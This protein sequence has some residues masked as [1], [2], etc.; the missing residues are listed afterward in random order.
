MLLI[1]TPSQL[2]KAALYFLFVIPLFLV[3]TM[4]I[5]SLPY[6]KI[7]WALFE[8]AAPFVLGICSISVFGLFRGK[9]WVKYFIQ[10]VLY[11]WC[12]FTFIFALYQES[13]IQALFGLVLS[14][15][16]L[17][18]F[19]YLKQVFN[20]PYLSPGMHWYQGFPETLPGLR[21]DMGRVA[22][23]SEE[24]VFVLGQFESLT[25]KNLP[26]QTT[27]EF[28]G[29]KLS[30]QIQPISAVSA[31]NPRSRYKGLGLQFI[32]NSKDFTKDIAD[33]VERLRGEGHV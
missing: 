18:Y 30:C 20:S 19:E 32:G 22:R 24:G 16:A 6:W 2:K 15:L 5:L 1:K 25:L 28:K 31:D 14:L 3:H 11:S 12:A 17:S 4:L 13:A 29:R 9:A 7:E 26:T 21:C 27:L 23:I 33:F 8:R 10:A